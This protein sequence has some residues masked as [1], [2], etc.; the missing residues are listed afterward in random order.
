MPDPD[1]YSDKLTPCPVQAGLGVRDIQHIP[2]RDRELRFT[3]NRAGGILMSSG[4]LLIVIAVFLQI[5]GHDTIAPYL[6]APLWV[7]QAMVLFPA[8]ICL[9]T[10]IRCL[11]H[12]AIIIT[13]VGVE[14]LPFFRARH[15]MQWFF[16]QQ[17]NTTET[18]R[19]KLILH[20]TNGIDITIHLFPITNTS[21]RLLLYAIQQRIT[22]IQAS[23]YGQA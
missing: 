19:N 10:A 22:S 18:Q 17:I 2:V 4:F 3:R 20:M 14:I 9:V 15:T 8:G 23:P 13:P 11:K 7:M 12:A 5:T 21:K 6:P 1:Q 16:W